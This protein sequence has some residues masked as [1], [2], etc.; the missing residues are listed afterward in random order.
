MPSNENDMFAL[1]KC[2]I[3]K[4]CTQLLI[5]AENA[6]RRDRFCSVWE[7]FVFTE[8]RITFGFFAIRAE[9]DTK[10]SHVHTSIEQFHT[11]SGFQRISVCSISYF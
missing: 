4:A 10:L 5:S 6:L 11:S 7:I 8:Q 9:T 2:L 1:N 3:E